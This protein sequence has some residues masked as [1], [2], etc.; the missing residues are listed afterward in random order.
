MASNQYFRLRAFFLTGRYHGVEWP[1]APARVFQALVAGV[2]TGAWRESVAPEVRSALV[3]LQKLQPPVIVAKQAQAQVGYRI[4]VPNN[5]MDRAAKDWSKGRSFDASKLRT[6]KNVAGREAQ[7][8]GPHVHYYWPIAESE[9]ATAQ[10]HEKAL[11]SAS[12][13]LHTL[14]WGIDMA[15]ADVDICTDLDREGGEVWKAGGNGGQTLAVPI[16]GFLEDLEG[17]YQRFVKRIGPGGVNA[18]T[19]PTVYGEERYSL[20]GKLSPSYLGFTLKQI[21]ANGK[22][23]VLKR[24]AAK[25]VAVAAWLRHA[26]IEAIRRNDSL[27]K[28]GEYVSGHGEAREG[29]RLSYVPLP[30]IGAAKADGWVRRVLIVA[31]P[32]AEHPSMAYLKQA[33]LGAQIEDERWG[34]V[35]TWGEMEKRDPVLLA[36]L[37]PSSGSQYWQS[38][39]PVVL[40][41]HNAQR[42][43]L[44]MH[45]TT[46]LVLEAFRKSGYPEGSIEDFYIQAA[47][48]VPQ[49]PAAGQFFLPKQLEKLPRYH[50]GVKF[51][52]SMPGPVLAGIG[53]HVG[54]GLFRPTTGK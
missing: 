42:G 31:P 8:E 16:E 32:G 47:P 38:V 20:E 19:R 43:R 22:E 41:G 40:H 21:G 34:V 12:H 10:N 53:R 13:C 36:Y 4:S 30:S 6:L 18:D 37:G 28:W 14:G 1:P 50:V 29:D 27:E 54:L 24:P 7:G 46:K 33:L 45:K 48:L 51:R 15:F 2:M 44:S 35:G 5:D 11:R 25:G 3:W 52:E 9:M 49:L 17:A 39:T 26:A 23:G